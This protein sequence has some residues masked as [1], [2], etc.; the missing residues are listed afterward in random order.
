M[1][2]L[3]PIWQN[4]TCLCIR[5]SA[6]QSQRIHKNITAQDQDVILEADFK[7]VAQCKFRI[8]R[9]SNDSTKIST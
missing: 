8:T 7:S 6:H 1:Y 3:C 5:L 4:V 2:I 9:K